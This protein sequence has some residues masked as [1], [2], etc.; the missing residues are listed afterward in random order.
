MPRKLLVLALLPVA[1][2]ATFAGV[3]FSFYQGGYDAPPTVDIPYDD[4]TS[5]GAVPAAPDDS[6]V[7]QNREGLLLVDAMHVNSVSE[8]EIASLTSLVADRGYDV[9]LLGNFDIGAVVSRLGQLEQK[10][11]EAD[12]FL[13][14]LPQATYSEAE[15]DVVERFVDKGGKLVLVSDPT[16]PSQINSLAKRFGVEFQPDYLYNTEEYDLNFRHIF[17]RDFQPSP[18][19]TGLETVALYITGSVQSSGDGLAFADARTR[20]SLENPADRHVAIALGDRRNVL[21]IADFTF[22][23]PPYNTLLDNGRLLSNLADFLSD[24]QREYDLGDFPHFYDGSPGDTVDILLGQTSLWDVG[25]TVRN[26]LSD[27]GISSRI[28]DEEDVSRNAVFL[29]LY[30]DSPAVGRYLQTAGVSI[31]ETI[32][33]P[34]APEVPSEGTSI[35]LLHR[36]Q[37]RYAL[38]ML[39]NTP[40][41]LAE[42]VYSLFSGEFRDTLVSDNMGLRNSP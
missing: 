18:L 30:E 3:F 14:M 40:G 15:V 22:M 29:G 24:N 5:P 4:I 38:V 9:E 8:R 35:A 31:N 34:F 19:T 33:L 20:S 32:S 1:A 13:V 16:R 28:S 11:R 41:G 12:S 10:L 36:S 6:R 42:A 27:Y 21:A 23:V 39:S 25:L 17:V 7:P 26:G 2:A 37:D